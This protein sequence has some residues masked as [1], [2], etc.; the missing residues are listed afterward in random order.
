[1]V[2]EACGAAAEASLALPA[3]PISP[4]ARLGAPNRM[5][6]P[7]TTMA[8]RRSEACPLSSARPNQPTASTARDVPTAPVKVPS[9][10]VRAASMLLG[11]LEDGAAF[12][13]MAGAGLRLGRSIATAGVTAIEILFLNHGKAMEQGGRLCQVH[14]SIQ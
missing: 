14:V 4:R 5:K 6:H 10:Q 7:I 12:A 2:R 8:P 9:S 13:I 1:M 3:S 11:S